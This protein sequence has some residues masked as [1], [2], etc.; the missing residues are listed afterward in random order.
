MRFRNALFLIA[1]I[2]LAVIL[3]AILLNPNSSARTGTGAKYNVDITSTGFSP[4][5]LNIKIGDTVI[6]TNKDTDRHWV[7]SDI[8]PTHNVYPE[9]GG[10]IGS[11]FDVCREMSKGESYEFTFFSKGSWCYHDHLHPQL[12]G[13]VDAQ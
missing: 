4:R 9:K 7:A 3:L 2:S 1:V 12:T 11:K 6:F 8:H 5:I 13:C 10:C